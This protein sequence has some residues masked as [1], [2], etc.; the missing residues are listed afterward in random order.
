MKAEQIPLD[1]DKIPDEDKFKGVL[2]P[3]E[4]SQPDYKKDHDWKGVNLRK[5][6]I[7]QKKKRRGAE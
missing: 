4:E 1:F 2:H 3:D 7:L 5:K 6:W